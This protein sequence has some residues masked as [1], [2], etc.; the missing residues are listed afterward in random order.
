MLV[1]GVRIVG[2]GSSCWLPGS[3]V[4]RATV[5]ES[6]VVVGEGRVWSVLVRGA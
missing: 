3:P 4:D 6:K 2:R 5:K 1:R